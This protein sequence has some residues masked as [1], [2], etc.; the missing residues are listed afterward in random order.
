MTPSTNATERLVNG[1]SDNSNHFKVAKSTVDSGHFKKN[2]N[3]HFGIVKGVVGGDM[4][5]IPKVDHEDTTEAGS[6]IFSSGNKNESTILKDD[7]SIFSQNVFSPL[8]PIDLSM[9]QKTSSPRENNEEQGPFEMSD[10]EQ[11]KNAGRSSRSI[12]PSSG[13]PTHHQMPKLNTPL[14]GQSPHVVDDEDDDYFSMK[15]N[16]NK[17]TE[18]ASFDLTKVAEDRRLRQSLNASRMQ[19]ESPLYSARREDVTNFGSPEEK[20]KDTSNVSSKNNKVEMFCIG[21]PGVARKSKP[22][23]ANKTPIHFDLFGDYR[24][25]AS[26]GS[27]SGVKNN[28][29]TNDESALILKSVVEQIEK[30]TVTMVKNYE[31][32]LEKVGDKSRSEESPLPK[33]RRSAPSSC[34]SLVLENEDSNINLVSATSHHTA[35]SKRE[36]QFISSS[37]SS[38]L[39]VFSDELRQLIKNEVKPIL[40]NLDD[41]RTLILKNEKSKADCSD[42][43]LFRG[44][45]FFLTCILTA[46]C[47]FAFFLFS[48]LAEAW[49]ILQK[50]D[51]F[52][53][54]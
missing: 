48:A 20:D 7:T 54:L 9:G 47:I 11:Q 35:V 25:T 38:N 46:V 43:G 8:K 1:P 22:D 51:G 49:W 2:K 19:E 18:R 39:M 6:P 10:G 40:E 26:M 41:Q 52:E 12:S 3:N 45:K 4:S 34:G 14:F 29:Q 50:D 16:D 37:S 32:I 44:K 23:S 53:V 5:N 36:N 42:G 31:E 33:R 30:A 21:S 15:D 17:T 27:E 24:N 13:G 28:H